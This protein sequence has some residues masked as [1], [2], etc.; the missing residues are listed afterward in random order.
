MVSRPEMPGQARAEWGGNSGA[1]AVGVRAGP[2]GQFGYSQHTVPASHSASPLPTQACPQPSQGGAGQTP[3]MKSHVLWRPTWEARPMWESQGTMLQM[4]K[5]RP[6]LSGFLKPPNL[7]HFP[8]SQPREGL[9]SNAHRAPTAQEKR[10]PLSTALA[11]EAAMA[12]LGG[13]WVQ[14]PVLPMG[15]ARREWSCG[16]CPTHGRQS[17]FTPQ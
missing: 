7:D 5:L 15:L 6:N 8:L 3:A 11:G 2:A 9:S 12:P 1:R 16:A 4:G 10:S 14:S 13:H 17:P